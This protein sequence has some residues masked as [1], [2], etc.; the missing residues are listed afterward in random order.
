MIYSGIKLVYELEHGLGM[1]R[2]YNL[3]IDLPKEALYLFAARL[4]ADSD[5]GVTQT[6]KDKLRGGNPCKT[7]VVF[8]CW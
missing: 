6:K 3:F 2:I 5:S 1:C 7:L 4:K 8:F